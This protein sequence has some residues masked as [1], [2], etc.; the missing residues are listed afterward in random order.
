M[1]LN[2]GL[3]TSRSANFAIDHFCL[4]FGLQLNGL[5][6]QRNTLKH[7]LAVHTD[8]TVFIV[9]AYCYHLVSWL[10]HVFKYRKLGIY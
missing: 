6:L 7:W 2:L 1:S 10:L 9:W 3:V 4:K 8:T 5:T